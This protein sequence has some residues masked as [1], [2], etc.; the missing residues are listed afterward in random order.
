MA[1]CTQCGHRLADGSKFCNE[2]GS[3]AGQSQGLDDISLNVEITIRVVL[4]GESNGNTETEVYLPHLGKTVAVR[5][6]N[7]ISIGQ[8][9]RLRGLGHTSHNGEKGDAYIRIVQIDYDN[10]PTERQEQ[11]RKVRYEGEVRKCPQCGETIN[12]FMPICPSCGHEMRNPSPTSVVSDFS[13]KIAQTASAEKREILIR[14]FYFPNTKEDIFEF[15]ILAITNLETDVDCADAWQAKLEQTYHKAKI[16]FGNT[17]EFEYIDKLYNQTHTHISKKVFSNMLRKN[18][19]TSITVLLIGTGIVMLII[20]I[21]L[22]MAF[23]GNFGGSWGGLMFAI[24]GINFLI[25]PTWVLEEMKKKERAVS[26]TN[27][28]YGRKAISMQSPRKSAVDFLHL[29]Y[30][31]V[32]EQLRELGFTN[33]VTKAEKKGLLDTEGAVKGISIAG[34][35]EFCADDEFDVNSKI[36]IRYYSRKY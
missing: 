27:D 25:A 28:S 8:S 10:T 1:F 11:Q 30:D 7:N 17:A 15:F 19:V 18:K 26:R 14:N 3:P 21:V 33:I 20:G 6:P 5:V 9:L 13:K 36:I 31:D 34:N 23:E 32:S 29:Q 35:A 22:L 24:I 4:K 12:A 2:C 16:A